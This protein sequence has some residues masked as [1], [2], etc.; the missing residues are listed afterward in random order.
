MCKDAR[1]RAF[2]R[3]EGDGYSPENAKNFKFWLKNLPK[4]LP[5]NFPKK[6]PKNCPKI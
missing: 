4:N 6:Q 5:K 1:G 3:L 2:M